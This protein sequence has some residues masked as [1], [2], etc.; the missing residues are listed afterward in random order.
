MTH[1]AAKP[2]QAPSANYNGVN[3]HDF[4]DMRAL[5]WIGGRVAAY[6]RARHFLQYSADELRFV[7][8]DRGFQRL[9][10]VGRG[11]VAFLFKPAESNPRAREDWREI[12]AIASHLKWQVF[13]AEEFLDT[14]DGRHRPYIGFDLASGPDMTAFQFTHAPLYREKLIEAFARGL[15]AKHFNAAH[16]PAKSRVDKYITPEI[17]ARLKRLSGDAT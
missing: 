15:A 9:Q 8:M 3:L 2:R 17:A 5:L 7:Q 14:I 10:E 4:A 16:G 13:D 12:H 1:E 6:E 11:G